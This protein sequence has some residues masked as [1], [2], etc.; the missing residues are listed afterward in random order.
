M[1]RNADL[2]AAASSIFN[3]SQIIRSSQLVGWLRN[4]QEEDIRE[5]FTR[6]MELVQHQNEALESLRAAVEML[7]E[8]ID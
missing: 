2:A 3:A 6:L 1:P 7:A 5:L 8:K 4:I